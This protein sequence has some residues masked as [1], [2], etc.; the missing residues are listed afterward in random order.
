M[1]W[2]GIFTRYLSAT[3]PRPHRHVV[4][5]ITLF[6]G[7]GGTSVGFHGPV[8]TYMSRPFVKMKGNGGIL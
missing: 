1:E 3:F 5:A 6:H 8:G 4:L 2:K 7:L